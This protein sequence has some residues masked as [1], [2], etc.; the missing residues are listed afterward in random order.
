MSRLIVGLFN[1]SKK[2]GELVAQL[3]NISLTDKISVI[4][5]TTSE[6]YVDLKEHI[7]KDKNLFEDNIGT[8]AILGGLFDLLAGATALI[9]PGSIL[10]AGPLATALIGLGSGIT[11]GALTG[12][13]IDMG[14]PEESVQ[15]YAD[16]IEAG[17]VLVAV[18]A[19]DEI[20]DEVEGLM[21][22]F[23]VVQ[24]EEYR[25]K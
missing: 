8:G 13:L 10:I 3:K 5:K 16:R 22:Q 20:V 12:L 25:E 17:D 24:I 2:A 14:V 1:D 6:G 21:K 23:Q 18:D 15:I 4:S 7:I 11:V 19:E 9:V